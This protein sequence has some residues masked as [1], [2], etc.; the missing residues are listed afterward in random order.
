MPLFTI[1]GVFDLPG[2]LSIGSHIAH[3][4]ILAGLIL[5]TLVAALQLRRATHRARLDAEAIRLKYKH[6]DGLEDIPAPYETK[7]R[8]IWAS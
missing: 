8:D 3:A 1:L 4:L 7:H 6:I 2:D 5:T